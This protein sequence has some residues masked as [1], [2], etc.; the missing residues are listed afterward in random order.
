MR[1]LELRVL[2]RSPLRGRE[3]SQLNLTEDAVIVAVRHNGATLIPRGQTRLETGDRVTV[4]AAASAVDEVRAMFEAA[5]PA[6]P[7]DR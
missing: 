3:L 5:G 4:I 2:P 1:Y 7:A 6:G